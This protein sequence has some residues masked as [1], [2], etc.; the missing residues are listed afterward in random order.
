MKRWKGAIV[1]FGKSDCPE[2]KAQWKEAI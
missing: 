1:S 2:K